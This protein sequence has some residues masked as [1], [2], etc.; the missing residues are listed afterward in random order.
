MRCASSSRTRWSYQSANEALKDE[1]GGLDPN[2][3]RFRENAQ[4]Q[5]EVMND[6]SNVAQALSELAKKTFAVGPEM[7]KEIGNALQQMG[8]A[9]EQMEGRNPG[10]AS[11]QQV[12]AMGS[13]N[14]AAMMMQGSLSGMMQG[15]KGG[16]G[17]GR[18][19][20]APRTDGGRPGRHQQRHAAGD[21]SE[22]FG[23]DRARTG[24]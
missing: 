1:T 5:S 7:G 9:T 12:Q 6:L 8:A 14:R 2:S 20:V 21:G 10:G 4:R 24:R 3:Q 16:H 19:D 17:H 15:G 11:G 22:R 18:D 23:R 13:L